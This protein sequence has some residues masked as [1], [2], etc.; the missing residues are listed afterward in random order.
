MLNPNAPDWPSIEDLS[1]SLR[2]YLVKNRVTKDEAIAYRVSKEFMSNV[3]IF[4]GGRVKC[5]M[6]EQQV[7][8]HKQQVEINALRSEIAVLK[9]KLQ[10]SRRVGTNIIHLTDVLRERLDIVIESQRAQLLQA[11]TELEAV[12]P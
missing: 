11:R 7:K 5:E 2:S 8:A 3:E 1:D 9:A 10:E 12:D 4:I 6:F